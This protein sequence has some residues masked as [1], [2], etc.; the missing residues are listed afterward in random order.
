M[1]R[2]MMGLLALIAVIGLLPAAAVP[3][4]AGGALAS[5]NVDLVANIPDAP[6]IG[7]R[8]LGDYMYVTGWQGLR[9]YDIA[10]AG[11]VAGAAAAGIPVLV[12]ALELPHFEN[13]DVD[14]NGEILLISADFAFRYPRGLL[15]VIDVTNKNAPL[16]KGAMVIPKGYGHTATCINGCTHAWLTGDSGVLIVDLTDPAAPKEAGRLA[17]LGFTHDVEQDSAGIA[18]V[19]NETGIWGYKTADPVNPTLWAQ[20]PMSTSF[21]FHNALRPNASE[22]KKRALGD[23]GRDPKYPGELLLI[24]EEDWMA[25]T[26]GLCAGDGDF[27]TASV[28]QYAGESEPVVTELDRLSLGNGLDRPTE[29][30]PYGV[31]SCSAHYFSVR[32]NVAAIGWYEQGTRFFDFS[33]PY[34]I[35]EAGY[36]MPAV[37]EVWAT[38]YNSGA[39]VFY[40]FDPARGIDVLRLTA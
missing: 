25:L 38:T 2:W 29:K 32:G 31:V 22:W 23:T 20:G 13:E 34:D 19:T 12:G 7:G 8:I 6:V 24:S 33:D 1:R 9:I 40:T 17:S 37:T 11:V 10:T 3:P 36:F 21:I 15:Y 14:T 5:K 30:K 39:D 35:Q 16:V 28:V 26:N 27:V 4:A 18:W